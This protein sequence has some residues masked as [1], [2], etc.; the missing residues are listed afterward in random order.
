M[1]TFAYD[2]NG[3]MTTRNLAG[4]PSQ[5]LVWDEGR[6]LE[7]VRVGNNV[8]AEFLYAIDDRRVRRITDGV[9]TY[10]LAD[11]SEY[12]IDGANSYFTYFHSVNG[13]MVAFWSSPV[14]RDTDT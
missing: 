4:Q 10:Y 9:A 13:R 8:E 11:G 14:L 3:N 2:N 5:T 7:E 1:S 12:T 6:R